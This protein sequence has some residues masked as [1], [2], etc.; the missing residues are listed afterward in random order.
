M[1]R[2]FDMDAMKR[3]W[4][5]VC[6]LAA[7]LVRIPAISTLPIDWDEPIYMESA[8]ALLDAFQTGSWSQI[9]SPTVNPEHPGLVKTIYAIGFSFFGSDID[10]IDR[11]IIVRGVS[12]VA[13]LALVVVA[14]WVHP[15]AGM[16]LATHTIHAKYS[17]EGY[18]DSLPAFCMSLAIV[19]AWKNRMHLRGTVFLLC[20]VLWGAAIAGK[21]VHGIPGLLLLWIWR[22][23][24]AMVALLVAA[25]ASAVLLDP[26]MWANPVQRILQMMQHHQA[27][28]ATVPDSS[29]WTPWVTL[30]GGGP[31]VWHPEIFRWSIDGVW[32]A[33]G[34]LGIGMGLK[35]PWGRLLAAWFCLP[36][37]VLMGWETRWPQHLTVVVMPVCLGVAIALRPLLNR[38]SHRFVPNDSHPPA[39][40]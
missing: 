8:Q 38:A 3:P 20:G 35:E 13:G 28:A 18:L 32:L 15:V 4:V 9:F 17:C 16:V 26:T 33:F 22:D 36:M 39:S 2:G 27:Y 29:M 14:A 11:L 40:A 30:A 6:V 21:W 24:R 5:W 34:L 31:A 1:G 19:W 7:L 23:W 12:L 25:T 37:I 10:L